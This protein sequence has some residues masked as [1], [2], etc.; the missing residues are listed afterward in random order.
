MLRV[1]MLLAWRAWR[2]EDWNGGPR[3]C[4]WVRGIG[5]RSWCIECME[6][7]WRKRGLNKAA[8]GAL[9]GAVGC[10]LVA[11]S[12]EMARA[13]QLVAFVTEQKSLAMTPARQQEMAAML[14]RENAEAKLRLPAGFHAVQA[15]A[16]VPEVERTNVVNTSEASR[17]EERG[18]GCSKG[19]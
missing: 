6:F 15:K 3:R 2:S 13:P 8:A 19:R 5:G 16:V 11:G 12:V 10:A 7:C 14:A 9:L 1:P 17:P 18:S 4:R